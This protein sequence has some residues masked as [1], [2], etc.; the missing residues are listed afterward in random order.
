[1]NIFQNFT[2]NLGDIKQANQTNVEFYR[3]KER[4]LIDG[5]VLNKEMRVMTI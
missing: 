4:L 5:V 2:D 1:M 3:E